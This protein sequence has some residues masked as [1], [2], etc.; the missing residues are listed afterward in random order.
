MKNNS[1]PE[2]DMVIRIEDCK[3]NLAIHYIIKK[4]I[5]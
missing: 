1:V 3:L 5:N 4:A 2:E